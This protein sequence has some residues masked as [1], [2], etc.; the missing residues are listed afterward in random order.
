MVSSIR[1]DSAWR[2]RPTTS[3]CS[4]A[5]VNVGT[6][7]ASV[8]YSIAAPGFIGLYQVAIQVPNGGTGNQNVV[9]TINGVPSNTVTMAVK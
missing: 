8:A 1:L 3:A 9:I 6:A 7:P 4:I 5:R 2:S